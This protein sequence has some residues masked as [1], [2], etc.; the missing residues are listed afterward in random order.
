MRNILRTCSKFFI[1]FFALNFLAADQNLK[2]A[3]TV[4]PGLAPNEST[5]FTAYSKRPKT[6]LSKLI[7]LLDLYKGS[8]CSV[9]YEG[10][11][12]ESDKALKQAK[13]YLARHYKGQP[14]EAWLKANAYRSLGK[15]AVIYLKSPDGQRI[16]LR[17]VLISELK[18]LD[19]KK[20]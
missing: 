1:F 2:A 7:Y 20:T 13:S 16:P 5:A 15:G 4:Q 19:S 11:D 8:P 14:A 18:K 17:D 9:I 10:I 3:S 6:E 12:Y